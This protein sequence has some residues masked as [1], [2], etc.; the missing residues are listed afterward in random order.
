[1]M[2]DR[3]QRV[4]ADERIAKIRDLAILGCAQIV[5]RCRDILAQQT[6]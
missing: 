1:M 4:E 6:I 2:A 3:D 5:L